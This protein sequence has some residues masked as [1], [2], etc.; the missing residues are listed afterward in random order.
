MVEEEVILAAPPIPGGGARS[1]AGGFGAAGQGG[2][3]GASGQRGATT[4]RAG[5]SSSEVAPDTFGEELA[6]DQRFRG[7]DWA[8][9]EPEARRSFEQRYPGSRWEQVK[10]AVSRGFEKIRQKL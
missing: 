2:V 3:A 7:R 9:A 1:Y 8:S 4:G 10:E 5:G 6:R